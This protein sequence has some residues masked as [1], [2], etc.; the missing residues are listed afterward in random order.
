MTADERLIDLDAANERLA[1]MNLNGD[2]AIRM[3]GAE[4]TMP[5]NVR[6][7]GVWINPRVII[8]APGNYNPDVTIGSSAIPPAEPT[9]KRAEAVKGKCQR[10]GDA[11]S[12]H[13]L[14]LT[15]DVRYCRRGT[16]GSTWSAPAPPVAASTKQEGGAYLSIEQVARIDRLKEEWFQSIEANTK[17]EQAMLDATAAWYGYLDELQGLR[18]KYAR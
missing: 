6:D 10:C 2:G 11:Y 16:A 15:E 3:V 9:R 14:G 12:R 5:E 4:V 7:D 1:A 18:A 13:K 17:A 8:P